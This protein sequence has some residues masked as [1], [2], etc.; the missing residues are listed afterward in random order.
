MP[1]PD[2]A[3]PSPLRRS[4]GRRSGGLSIRIVS[5]PGLK[6]DPLVLLTGRWGTRGR[7]LL[8]GG[9]GGP[10]MERDERYAIAL[11]AWVAWGLEAK[12]STP[13]RR[14]EADIAGATL[15]AAMQQTGTVTAVVTA[16]KLA[17]WVGIDVDDFVDAAAAELVERQVRDALDAAEWR[18]MQDA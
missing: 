13:E 6:P 5:S 18:R 17:A 11:R 15:M 3:S 8:Y 16:D 2:G 9:L 14:S 12:R 7:S 4:V 1:S 10:G